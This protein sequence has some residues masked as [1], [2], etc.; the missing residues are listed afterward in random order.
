MYEK[1][2]VPGVLIECGF[3]TNYFDRTNLQNSKYQQSLATVI[4]EATIYYFYN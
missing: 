2:N 3:L 4:S 1:L